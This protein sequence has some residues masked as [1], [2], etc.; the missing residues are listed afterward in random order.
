MRTVSLPSN[1]SA[2]GLR[3]ASLEQACVGG[4]RHRPS[5]G[6]VV[7]GLALD[8]PGQDRTGTGSALRDEAGRMLLEQ[9]RGGGAG[10]RPP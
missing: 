6:L 9:T 7:P 10:S 8:E 5:L 2:Q 1:S 4:A 3:S